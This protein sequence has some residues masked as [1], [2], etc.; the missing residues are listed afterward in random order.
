MEITKTLP[1]HNPADENTLD[2]LNNVLIDK[3]AMGIQNVIPAIVQSY[4]K[5]TNR[6]VVKPAITG[7]ASQGQKVPKEP[8]IDIPVLNISGGGFVISFPIKTGDTGWLIACDRNISIFKQNLE[9]SAPNDYRK[10]KFED[11]FF[12]PDKINNTPLLNTDSLLIQDATGTISIELTSSGV[13]IK[14]ITAITGN[15]S[16]VGNLTV[17]TGATGTFTTANSKT[18]T[19]TNGIVTNIS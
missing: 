3:I 14:G 17:S 18:V 13:N 10:H 16:V 11:G 5:A 7:I 6:A 2:G 19:V 1:A 12:I 8:Y 15:T 4:D 9:E